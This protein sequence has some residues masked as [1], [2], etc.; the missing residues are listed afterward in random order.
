MLGLNHLISRA[1]EEAGSETL[2]VGSTLRVRIPSNFVVTDGPALSV[3]D[4]GKML[5]DQAEINNA[6]VAQEEAKIEAFYSGSQWGAAQLDHFMAEYAPGNLT[7]FD[8]STNTRVPVTQEWVNEAV[9]EIVR[10][11]VE[12]SGD[13]GALLGKI[14]AKTDPGRI[15][16]IW[17][18]VRAASAV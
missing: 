8:P 13:G 2:K 6:R 4:Y 7:R 18:A 17:E 11:N 15:D 3:R 12:L 10:L 1:L 5:A 9:A 16:R 14:S